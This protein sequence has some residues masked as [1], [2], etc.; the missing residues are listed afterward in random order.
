MGQGSMK[1]VAFCGSKNN[2]VE[3]GKFEAQNYIA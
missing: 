1:V 2:G 3:V